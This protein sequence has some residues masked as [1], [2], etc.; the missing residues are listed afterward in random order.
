MITTHTH[1]G[2]DYKVTI[3]DH[4]TGPHIHGT[5]YTVNAIVSVI[6]PLAS[7]DPV[8]FHRLMQSIIEKIQ[9]HEQV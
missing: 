1:N 5:V 9:E 8:K 6:Y 7:V 4:K 3:F 2:Q